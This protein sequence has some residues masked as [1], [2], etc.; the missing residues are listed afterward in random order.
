MN[1]YS[2]FWSCFFIILFLI[3][4]AHTLPASSVSLYYFSS[5]SLLASAASLQP[6]LYLDLPFF[7]NKQSP[8]YST[9]IFLLWGYR[10]IRPLASVLGIFLLNQV[11]PTNLW[12]PGSMSF[13]DLQKLE[14]KTLGDVSNFCINSK[15]YTYKIQLKV[16]LL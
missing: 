16:M 6:F 15:N 7:H 12:W 5:A 1:S 10:S 11:L 2:K 3:L 14:A 8:T 4:K 13:S 9:T